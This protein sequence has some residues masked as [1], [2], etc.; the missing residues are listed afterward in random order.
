[1]G[2]ALCL[3]SFQVFRLV[4]DCLVRNFKAP[5]ENADTS[6]PSFSLGSSIL[7]WAPSTV[8]ESPTA[9]PEGADRVHGAACAKAADASTSRGAGI[10]AT[11]RSRNVS[12]RSASGRRLGG[13]PNIARTPR[14]KANTH[15]PSASAVS[16][17]RLRPRP[18]NTQRLRRR[19]VTQ[20]KLFF[21]SV[22]RSARLSRAPRE[23]ASQPGSVLW[24]RLPSSGSQR[25]GPRTQVALARHLGWS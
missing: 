8:S 9:A 22:V 25:P 16:A 15:G 13:R 6:S 1:M 10:S 11:A 7:P 5:G 24:P 14:P 20:Q 2:F 3:G 4:G 12:A 17:P 23:L 18:W 21:S 19:V